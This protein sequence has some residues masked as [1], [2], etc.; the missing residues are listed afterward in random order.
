MKIHWWR[1]AILWLVFAVFLFFFLYFR[2]NQAVQ[3][4][5]VVSLAMGYFFWGIIHHRLEK[6]LYWPVV[7]EYFLIA[8]FGA[9]LVIFL[10]LRK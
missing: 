2:Y 1:Y 8:L 5:C 6:N 4:G 3:V 7:I 9:L 10:I